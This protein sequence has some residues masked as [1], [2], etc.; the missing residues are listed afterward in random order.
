MIRALLGVVDPSA[1]MLYEPGAA[2]GVGLDRRYQ[3]QGL[4]PPAL[5]SPR[6]EELEQA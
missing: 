5:P 2:P 1:A 4:G 6:L 3:L